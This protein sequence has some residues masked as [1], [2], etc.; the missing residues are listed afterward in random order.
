MASKM[1][2]LED[3]TLVEVEVSDRYASEVSSKDA[4]AIKDATM[5]K[6]GSIALSA[7][8]SL[9]GIWSEVN[10]EMLIDQAQLQLALGFEAEGNLFIAKSKASAG[11]TLTLTLKPHQD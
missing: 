3:G 1:I 2:K 10:Q 9:K 6:M 4:V 8:R 11:I 5:D 7:A